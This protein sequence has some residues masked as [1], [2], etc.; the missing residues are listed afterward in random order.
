MPFPFIVLTLPP[1][2]L[3][4]QYIQYKSQNKTSVKVVLF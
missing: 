1:L 2:M 4:L 3:T